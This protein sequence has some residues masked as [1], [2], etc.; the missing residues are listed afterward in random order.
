M[1]V[2]QHNNV[3]N[4]LLPVILHYWV[5]AYICTYMCEESSVCCI[6]GLNYIAHLVES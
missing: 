3:T 5:H 6:D 1:N 2:L 4:I